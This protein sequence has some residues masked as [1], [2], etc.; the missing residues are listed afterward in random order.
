MKKENYESPEFRFQELQLLEKVADKC[1]GCQ[2]VFVDHDD[3]DS[4]APKTY[5]FPDNGCEGQ[6]EGDV[7]RRLKAL[8]D[9]FPEIADKVTEADVKVNVTGSNFVASPGKSI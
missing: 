7:E 3:D 9:A 8:K 6:F 2:Y 4:T 5:Y 1:W